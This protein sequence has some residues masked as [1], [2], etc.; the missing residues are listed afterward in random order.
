MR[1]DIDTAV[2]L[3]GAPGFERVL[4]CW[5][6]D[7][8]YVSPPAD[9]KVPSNKYSQAGQSTCYLDANWTAATTRRHPSFPP[10]SAKKSKIKSNGRLKTGSSLRP[11]QL[12]NLCVLE[13]GGGNC[14]YIKCPKHHRHFSVE[15]LKQCKHSP[16][17]RKVLVYPFDFT[18]AD[19]A[20]TTPTRHYSTGTQQGP[21][22]LLSTEM[23]PNNAL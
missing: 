5:T 10:S 16:T 9:P 3:P 17:R 8:T 19:C 15:N 20:G 21:T 4:R 22:L 23:N 6:P 13:N 1:V 12:R 11:L 14:R 18:P 7:R 2:P